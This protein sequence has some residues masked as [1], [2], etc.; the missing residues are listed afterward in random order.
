MTQIDRPLAVVVQSPPSQAGCTSALRFVAA[1]AARPGPGVRIALNQNDAKHQMTQRAHWIALSEKLCVPLVLC[2][3][4][5][6]RYG[7]DE[8][9]L[10]APFILGSLTQLLDAY[11]QQHRVIIFQ[12]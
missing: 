1:A 12:P 9:N 5:A 11:A 8:P 2:S 10:K 4:A 3:S 7:I 6:N